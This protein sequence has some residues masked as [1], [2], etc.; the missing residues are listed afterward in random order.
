MTPITLRWGVLMLLSFAATLA[1]IAQPPNPEPVLPPGFDPNTGKGPGL[2]RTPEHSLANNLSLVVKHY[3][4]RTGRLPKTWADLE[5]EFGEGVWESG[6]WN[7]IKRRFAFV[8]TEGRIATREQGLVEG[9]LLVA[10]LY[11]IREPRSEEEG[12]F[13]IW[14]LNS[15]LV[16]AIWATESELQ[17]FSNWSEVVTKLEAA[18]AAVAQMPP[19]PI[20]STPVPPP[21]ATRTASP[22]PRSTM[23]PVSSLPAE[24]KPLV[25]PWMVGILAVLMIVTLAWK[26]RR[27]W[28][29]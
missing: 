17:S 4:M 5:Q 9:T 19:L 23:L 13:A 21:R 16:F 1:M 15:G 2:R 27:N 29:K 8:A 28:V 7:I 24:R 18:K 26:R 14:K 20:M 11:S 10:P 3:A 25:W 12:R 22:V 6:Q